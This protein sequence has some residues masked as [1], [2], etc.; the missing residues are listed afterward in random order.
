M[1]AGLRVGLRDVGVVD[2]LLLLFEG[3]GRGKLLRGRLRASR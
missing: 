2:F 1:D 3:I